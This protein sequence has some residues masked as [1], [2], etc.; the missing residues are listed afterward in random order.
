MRLHIP[1]TA[2]AALIVFTAPARAEVVSTVEG[3]L[4]I[5]NVAQIAA[6]PAKVYEALGRIGSW[7][8]SSHTYSG[9]AAN[10][11]MRLEPGACFCE[12]LPGGGVKHGEVVLA[13]PGQTLRVLGAFGPLQELGAAA[14]LTFQ[15]KPGNDGGTQ[16]IQTY[17]VG[18]LDQGTLKLA[19]VI[20][21]VIGAQLKG[22]K[23]HVETTP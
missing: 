11:T 17:Q 7:W 14:A 20:D 5:R 22:L 15:L 21:T 23:R 10:M 18:G 13:I 9:N 8:E 2:F 16:V 1:M 12:A 19:P 3:R 4:V 6:P